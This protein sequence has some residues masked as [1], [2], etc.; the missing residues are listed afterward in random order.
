VWRFFCSRRTSQIRA[1][2]RTPTF[3]HVFGFALPPSPPV[4][5]KKAPASPPA[6]FNAKAVSNLDWKAVKADLAK[7]MTDSQS[8]WPADFGRESVY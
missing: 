4:Q 6:N 2:A 1:S 8:W 7:L 5:N 3:S